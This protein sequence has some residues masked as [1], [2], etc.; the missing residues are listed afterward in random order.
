MRLLI[1]CA[2]LVFATSVGAQTI[3]E[4]M[5]A[6]TKALLELSGALKMGDQMGNAISRQIIAAMNSQSANVPAGA[7]EVVVEVVRGHINDFI[8][9][10]EVVDGLVAIYAKYYTHEEILA[11][12]KIYESPLGMKM[13]ESGQPI[14]LESSQLGQSLFL[15]RVPQIQKDIQESLQAAGLVLAPPAQPAPAP[16]PAQE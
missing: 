10:P 15:P 12:R 5:E 7:A 4:E 9:S 6:D 16:A 14:A 13:V 8:N 1:C 3:S 11:L 2:A